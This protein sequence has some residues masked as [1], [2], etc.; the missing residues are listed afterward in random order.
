MAHARAQVL[1]ETIV[2]DDPDAEL[3]L[4]AIA[5]PN[6]VELAAPAMG[7]VPTAE[8]TVHVQV[9]GQWH[10]RTPDLKETACG[11]EYNGEFSR[12]RREALTLL[13]GDMCERCFTPHELLRA[14]QADAEATDLAE[15]QQQRRDEEAAKRA[16]HA[17]P[18][19]GREEG[20]T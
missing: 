13:D 14:M 10:R 12:T 19:P 6:T 2:I 20:E 3:A 15:A 1:E 16:S 9:N 11:E 7:R 4:P 18:V 5:K 8:L 17:W